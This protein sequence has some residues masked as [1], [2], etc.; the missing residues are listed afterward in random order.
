[1]KKVNYPQRAII[2]V[3]KPDGHKQIHV[4]HLSGGLIS[5]DIFAR[6]LRNR[7]G[8]D[9]VLFFSG[10]ECYGTAVYGEYLKRQ[11]D[12]KTIQEYVRDNFLKQEYMLKKFQID[13]NEFFCDCNNKQLH[14][15]HEDTCKQFVNC[16]IEN[17][18]ILKVDE[19]IL[20]D[21]D[22]DCFLNYRQIKYLN[23][24]DIKQKGRRYNTEDILKIVSSISGKPPVEKEV[25]NYYINILKRK[26]EIN[27]LHNDKYSELSKY[28]KNILNELPNIARL[29]CNANS[30]VDVEINGES[31]KIWNWI[32]SLIAPISYTIYY[33]SE[34]NKGTN[35][36]KDWWS[37]DDS[38]IYHF[39]AQDNVFFY[40]ILENYLIQSWNKTNRE[41]INFPQFNLMPMRTLF[42]GKY[43]GPFPTGEMLLD[44]Y[45]V[46]SLRY[47]FASMGDGN[48]SF[49]PEK[50][51]DKSIEKD[52]IDF[53]YNAILKKI[54]RLVG[55]AISK[56]QE[57]EKKTTASKEA[58]AFG[59]KLFNRYENIM[60]NRQF[61]KA[62]DLI[63]ENFKNILNDKENIFY[64]TKMIIVML[65][66]FLPE[67]M[68]KIYKKIYTDNELY[69][70]YNVNNPTIVVQSFQTKAH[71]L[72][73]GKFER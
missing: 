45:S 48:S 39:M 43:K 38:E 53:K 34:K 25:Q 67:L 73:I 20:V 27:N 68:E 3:G 16:L 47:T 32:D 72:D 50:L 64:N 22:N 55:T 33:L 13:L 60:F 1:M 36:W 6:F 21:P 19:K 17:D 51:I 65:Y 41:K 10:T 8:R 24:G 23:D 44:N 7:I 15:I 30:G 14:K 5:S 9:N 59:S 11:Q 58:V 29:T 18:D 31:K 28:T 61:S 49:N 54:K 52:N 40:T 70:N 26:N 63:E 62:I 35:D 66:P 56:M 71:L 37:K 46:E 12:Y 69:E 57:N 42:Y 2:T 4:G